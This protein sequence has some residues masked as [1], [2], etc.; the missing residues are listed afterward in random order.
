[1][2][3]APKLNVEELGNAVRKV[4]TESRYRRKA[5]EIGE[6][7]RRKEGRTNAVNFL[8]EQGAKGFSAFM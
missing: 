5:A 2:S 7:C 1:M 8:M 4:T 6:L 3:T